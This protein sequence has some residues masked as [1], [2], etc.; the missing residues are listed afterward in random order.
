LPPNIG[1]DL[2][3][4]LN[5]ARTAETQARQVDRIKEGVAN[6]TISED[7]ASRLLDQQARVADAVSRAQADGVVTP[8][9]QARIRRMQ[10]QASADIFEARGSRELS[11]FFR[12]PSVTQRQAEQIGQI[13]DGIRNGELNGRESSS[14]LREQ[15]DIARDV[16]AAQSDDFR[17]DGFEKFSL[18][19]KQLDASQNIRS[20]STDLEKAPHGRNPFRPIPIRPIPFTF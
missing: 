1:K 5:S 11:S 8:L 10:A 15:A 20:Q 7:E 3:N 4:R 17:V 18:A 2:I 19:M 16:D 13:A 6:G 9:E 12:D 14:L